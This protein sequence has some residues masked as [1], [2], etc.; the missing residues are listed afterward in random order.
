MFKNKSVIVISL[1]LLS[2]PNHLGHKIRCV[3][4]SPH[5][6]TIYFKQT[7]SPSATEAA[8]LEGTYLCFYV[9][10]SYDICLLVRK[11]EGTGV[12]HVVNVSFDVDYVASHVCKQLGLV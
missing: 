5:E 11:F 6:L 4:Y 3:E 12:S 1:P 10:F 9:D 8:R 7:S 2:S